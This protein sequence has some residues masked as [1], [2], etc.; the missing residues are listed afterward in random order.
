[1]FSPRCPVVIPGFSTSSTTAPQHGGESRVSKNGQGD[2]SSAWPNH[3]DPLRSRK[4]SAND[5]TVYDIWEIH[6]NIGF[7][8]D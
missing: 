7:D 6:A 3:H 4:N 1:M 8:M 2:V 5:N